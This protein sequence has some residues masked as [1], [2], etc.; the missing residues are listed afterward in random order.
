MGLLG[1]TERPADMSHGLSLA[2]GHF[3]FTQ[4]VEDLF[5]GVSEPR[6][7]ALLSARP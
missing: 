6:H 7:T 3:S 5:D 4:L 1:D 2:Q